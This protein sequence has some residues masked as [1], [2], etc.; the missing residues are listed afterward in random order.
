VSEQSVAAHMRAAADGSD[1]RGDR[2]PVNVPLKRVH[3]DARELGLERLSPSA[4]ADASAASPDRE[5]EARALASA[6]RASLPCG[7]S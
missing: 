3:V 6:C 4:T 7:R 2:I 5:R 1:V